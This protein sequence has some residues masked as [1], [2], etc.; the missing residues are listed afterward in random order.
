MAVTIGALVNNVRGSSVKR[1]KEASGRAVGLVRTHR[2]LLYAGSIV[3]ALIAIYSGLS[4]VSWREA[5]ISRE[6]AQRASQGIITALQ[7]G[8]IKPD[9]LLELRTEAKKAASTSCY[10]GF[11]VAWQQVLFASKKDALQ[12][13]DATKAVL[14]QQAA[15]LEEL[16]RHL[17]GEMSLGSIMAQLAKGLQ[18]VD[19]QTTATRKKLWQQAANQLAKSS[20]DASLRDKLIA[21][22][23]EVITALDAL[24]AANTAQDVTKFDEASLKVQ[25]AY[26][27]VVG[28]QNQAV[29]L[30]QKKLDTLIKAYA[31]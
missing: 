18:S 14:Q 9:R 23:R 16:A 27:A 19:A 29:E 25:Q 22:V 13:C 17:E 10:P 8:G 31:A 12:Q 4:V 11:L 7:A 20:A 28:V 30:Y 5:E 21:R 15:A 2:Y 26:S 3:M 1:V 6:K 24:E